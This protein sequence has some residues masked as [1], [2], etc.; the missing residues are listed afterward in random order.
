M[1]NNSDASRTPEALRARFEPHLMDTF[2][3][4][5]VLF[6]EGRIRLHATAQLECD[7]WGITVRLE[8]ET[9]REPF[10]VSGAWEILSVW[11]NRVG[12]AYVNWGISVPAREEA[13]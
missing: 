10:T 7:E 3:E 5:R 8:P 12:A 9:D 2:H 6:E 4:Q 11:R 13:P 1:S